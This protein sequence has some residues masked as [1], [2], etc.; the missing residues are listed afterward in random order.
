VS[1]DAVEDMERDASVCEPGRSGVA[2]SVP[3]EAG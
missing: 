2:E 3:G 1:K